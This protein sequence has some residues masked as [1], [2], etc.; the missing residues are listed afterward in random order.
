MEKV[1][2]SSPEG[3]GCELQAGG[4]LP[5]TLVVKKIE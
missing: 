1:V 4:E 2:I 5:N 3:S